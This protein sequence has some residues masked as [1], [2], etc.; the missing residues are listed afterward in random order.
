M[1]NQSP[2]QEKS[3][4]SQ[5]REFIDNTKKQVKEN[6][7]YI[8]IVLMIIANAILSLLQV[9]GGQIGINYPKNG[10]GW[11]L[12]V[13]QV[14]AVT[15]I[16]V[17][18]LNSFRR[19]GTKNGHAVIKDTYTKYLE[20]ISK[21]T[22]DINPRSLK[23]YLNER[24]LKDSLSKGTIFALLNLL[25]LSVGISFNLNAFIGLVINVI[26]AV[27]FG[28]KA[29]LDAEDYV[30]TELVIWYKLKIKEMEKENDIKENENGN[31]KLRPRPS[32]SSRV[33]QTKESG[34]GQ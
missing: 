2:T 24:N 25:A 1:E 17:L 22:K 8:Y 14:L 9:N 23:Q 31:K 34:T 6:L 3:I 21:Q 10:L 12:W 27:C 5:R 15:F 33:Q 7:N 30:I 19:Q 29:M 20:L 16:G 13:T 28:I 26:V 4:D 11:V 18:I 32:K